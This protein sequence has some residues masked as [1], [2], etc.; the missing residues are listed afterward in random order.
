MLQT[1]VLALVQSATEF[2]PISSSAHLI[3][4]P[5]L[6]SWADQG[7]PFDVA[8]H[9]G[10]LAA[11][12]IYFRKDV[13][14]IIEGGF[15]VLRRQTGSKVNLFLCLTVATIPALLLGFVLEAVFHADFR[16]IKLLAFMLIFFGIILY[17]VD[18]LRPRTRTMAELTIKDAFYIGL[19]QAIAL[20]PGT[21]RSGITMTMA[22]YLGFNREDA[23]RFSML[24]SIPTI[25]AAGLWTALKI[26]QAGDV[27]F[28]N[29]EVMLGMAVSA[30]GGILAIWFLL[31]WLKKASFGIFA[32]YRIA[33]GVVLL[34]LTF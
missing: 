5:Y 2:L 13:A 14:A 11:V 28:L 30:V 20:I 4:I 9:I 24:L 15:G 12:V 25:S 17:L 31:A 3:I 19:A 32:A 27:G 29:P 18:K 7:M 1:I 21:S 16:S 26:Y 22:R 6:S 10:T 33:L 8:M 23:A 34:F